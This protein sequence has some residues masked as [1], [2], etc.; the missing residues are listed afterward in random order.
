MTVDFAT[1]AGGPL[2]AFRIDGINPQVDTANVNAFPLQVFFST[3]TGSFTQTAL[4]GVPEPGTWSLTLLSG[5]GFACMRIRRLV[6]AGLSG[7]RAER[8]GVRPS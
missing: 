3:A 4:T 6:R 7:N 2:S 5:M 8:A 1:L